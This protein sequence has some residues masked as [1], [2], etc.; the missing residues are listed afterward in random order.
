MKKYFI[1]VVDI[2]YVDKMLEIHHKKKNSIPSLIYILIFSKKLDKFIMISKIEI[3]IIN[4]KFLFIK[5]NLLFF[6]IFGNVFVV[7]IPCIN[8]SF[9]FP[10]IIAKLGKFKTRKNMLVG[11][12]VFNPTI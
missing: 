4:S 10:T 11:G 5:S 3:I 6:Q 8:F 2:F 12:K 1:D 9:F 7:Y